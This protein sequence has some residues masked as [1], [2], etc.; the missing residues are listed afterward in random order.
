MCALP[1][2]Q[3][4]RKRNINYNEEVPFELKPSAGFFDTAEEDMRT[5]EVAKVGSRLRLL[6]VQICSTHKGCSM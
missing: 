1:C 3:Q 2:L 4:K 6:L 5:K